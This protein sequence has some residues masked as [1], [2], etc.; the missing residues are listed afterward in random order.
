VRGKTHV[1]SKRQK[2]ELT[3]KQYF[4]HFNNHDWQK[5]ADMYIDNAEFK[6]SAIETEV[7][8]MLKQE[9]VAKYLE[10][11]QHVSRPERYSD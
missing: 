2:N 1:P 3:V 10:Y 4:E 8:T 6:D 11:R 7:F 5:M 9:I